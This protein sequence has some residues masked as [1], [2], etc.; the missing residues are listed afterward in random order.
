MALESELDTQLFIRNNKNIELTDAGK[1]FNKDCDLFIKHM[2]VITENVQAASQGNVGTLRIT[3]PGD[4]CKTFYDSLILFQER[5]PSVQLVVEAYDFNEIP[6][7]IQY[8]VY[9]IG[10]TFDF[11]TTTYE[12]E[13]ES[14]PIGTD[15]FSLAV[16]SKL[17]PNPSIDSISE[18]VKSLPMVLPYYTEPPFL[19]R[20]IHELQHYS[21]VKKI[22]TN[23][24][25]TT[26]SVMLDVSLGLGFSIIPTCVSISKSGMENISY[27][28]LDNFA[29]GT[30]VML[31]KKSMTSGLLNSFVDIVKELSM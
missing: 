25:N 19:K 16:S 2:Q 17:F 7:A 24:V 1:V 6:T 14:I 29:N 28:Q 22:K 11:A 18:I 12:D 8:G 9:N 3:S 27:I 13:I 26:D 30:I 5:F 31:Y 21:G 23:Y 20:I 4:L 15:V 10:F